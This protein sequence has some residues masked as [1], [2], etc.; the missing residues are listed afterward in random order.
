MKEKKVT[1]LTKKKYKVT[2][3]V[4]I[5]VTVVMTE[6]GPRLASQKAK[7]YIMD[8]LPSAVRDAD[9]AKIDN[10]HILEVTNRKTEVLDNYKT[11]ATERNN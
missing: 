2:E 9:S 4:T 10:A 1:N 5:D 3:R 11:R 7:L 6:R 8:L